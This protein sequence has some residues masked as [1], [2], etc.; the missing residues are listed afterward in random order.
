MTN[1]DAPRLDEQRIRDAA[2]DQG[3][4]PAVGALRD[5]GLEVHLEQT[6][7]FVINAVVPTRIGV[8]A[9]IHIGDGEDDHTYGL[10]AYTHEAWRDGEDHLA[11]EQ[12]T[13]LPELVNLVREL[14]HR[15]DTEED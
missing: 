15:L 11:A 2:T 5:A 3:L 7:G 12:A 14:M 10:A 8:V 1:H 4:D 13:S 9:V 6:G